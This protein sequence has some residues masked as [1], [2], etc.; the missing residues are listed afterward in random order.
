MQAVL[1][2]FEGLGDFCGFLGILGLFE[3]SKNIFL[4]TVFGLHKGAAASA[5]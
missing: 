5:V 1:G 3:R 4:F 2:G